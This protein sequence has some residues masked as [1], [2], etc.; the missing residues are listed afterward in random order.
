MQRRCIIYPLTE[1]T[2]KRSAEALRRCPLDLCRKFG[3]QAVQIRVQKA[4]E[5]KLYG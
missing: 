5:M 4:A 3:C 2:W 1:R